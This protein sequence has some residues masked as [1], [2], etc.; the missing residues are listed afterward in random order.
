MG[1]CQ[2]V[3]S[4]DRLSPEEVKLIFQDVLESQAQKKA[5]WQKLSKDVVTSELTFEELYQRI[6]DAPD[7]SMDP[8]KK[9][10]LTESDL[11]QLLGR[12]YRDPNL[13]ETVAKIWGQAR[14]APC[15]RV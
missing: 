12:H 13:K 2:G 7:V 9:Y 15:R 4:I 8:L 3:Q 5:N 6:K 14:R 10:D 1:Q 11:D